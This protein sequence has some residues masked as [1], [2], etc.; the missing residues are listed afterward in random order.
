MTIHK[1]C[2]VRSMNDTG[3]LRYGLV[4]YTKEGDYL[5]GL[6]VDA[7]LG[8]RPGDVAWQVRAEHGASL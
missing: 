6:R 3:T 4:L 7:A 2:S 8:P 1:M 5:H